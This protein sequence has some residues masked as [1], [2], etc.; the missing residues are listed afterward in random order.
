MSLTGT[1]EA[2]AALHEEGLNVAIGAFRAA[3]PW[4]FSYATSM[5]GGGPPPAPATLLDPISIPG[6]PVSFHYRMDVTNLVFDCFPANAG[7]GLP[8]ELA[9]LAK[10]EFSMRADLELTVLCP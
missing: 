4:Y 10:E 6:T 2:Y 7:S 5:L 1:N 3:R 9:P 8:A